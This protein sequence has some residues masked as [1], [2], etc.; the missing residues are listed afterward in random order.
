M[1]KTLYVVAKAV[2]PALQFPPPRRELSPYANNSHIAVWG[3]TCIIPLV[4]QAISD[5]FCLLSEHL[6]ECFIHMLVN[7]TYILI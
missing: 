1:C 2:A 5:V 6:G 3:G 7:I 4:A